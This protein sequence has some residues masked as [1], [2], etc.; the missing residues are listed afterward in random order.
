MTGNA[1]FGDFWARSAASLIQ[2][3]GQPVTGHWLASERCLDAREAADRPAEAAAAAPAL[4]RLLTVITRYLDDEERWLNPGGCGPW[5]LALNQSRNAVCQAAAILAEFP[6]ADR[7]TPGGEGGVA[8]DLSDAAGTLLLARDLL[9]THFATRPD[10]GWSDRSDWAPVIAS[11]QI[12]RAL[13]AV[14]AAHARAAA[15][16]VSVLLLPDGSPDPPGRAAL[17]RANPWLIAFDK[18]VQDAHSW[19]PVPDA[20]LRLLEAIPLNAVAGRQLPTG[21][22]QTAEL[23]AGVISAAERVQRSARDLAGRAPWDPGMNAASMRQTAAACIVASDSCEVILRSLAVRARELGQPKL[24]DFLDQVAAKAAGARR[25][26]M[27]TAQGWD[28]MTTDA[29]GRI[30]PSAADALGMALWTGRLAYSDPSWTPARGP[31]QNFREPGS[32][33]PDEAGLGAVIAAVHYATAAVMRL[34]EAGEQQTRVAAAAGRL[35]VTTRS[36]PERG[37]DVPRRMA[38]APQSRVNAVLQAYSRATEASATSTRALAAAADITGAPSRV[39]S[40]AARAVTGTRSEPLPQ[41]LV[42]RLLMQPGM[43]LVAGANPSYRQR[44]PGRAANRGTELEPGM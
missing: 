9:Q 33:A 43:Q 24:R 1:T 8:R 44:L 17:R 38:K 28:H 10:G 5:S 40:A 14:L 35:Y 25:T 26:W 37:Y 13:L 11:E 15:A 31:S 41:G 42:M 36:L 16:R 34:G 7:E 19:D 32:L 29:P 12:S 30:T 39:L 27:A 20:D 3:Q 18:A 23:A 6:A 2:G 4:R 21:A 22:E